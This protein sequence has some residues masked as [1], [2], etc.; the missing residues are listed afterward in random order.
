MKT[1][2]ALSLQSSLSLEEKLDFIEKYNE[3]ENSTVEKDKLDIII[4]PLSI[5][6]TLLAG[7]LIYGILS[8]AIG[9]A[10][11]SIF[12]PTIIGIGAICSIKYKKMIEE[13]FNHKVSYSDFKKLKR[14]GYIDSWKQLYK[15]RQDAKSNDNTEK[16][17]AYV[18]ESLSCFYEKHPNTK[19]N[20]KQVAKMVEQ[21]IKNKN[22]EIER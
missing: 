6:S 11:V 7:N 20:A 22:K 1:A 2:T 5:L 21:R 4:T 15:D 18:S 10:L 17:Q 13:A 9:I 8:P 14:A 3:I 19:V 16:A 12:T